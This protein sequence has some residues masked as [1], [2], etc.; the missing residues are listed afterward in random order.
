MIFGSVPTDLRFGSC[1][2]FSFTGSMTPRF[3][4]VRVC[5]FVSVR[6]HTVIIHFFIFITFITSNKSNQPICP[7]SSVFFWCLG[8]I[9]WTNLGS[10]TVFPGVNGDADNLCVNGYTQAPV[11]VF[12]PRMPTSKNQQVSKRRAYAMP[13]T[14][15]CKTHAINLSNISCSSLLSRLHDQ[16]QNVA[17]LH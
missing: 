3:V 9:H 14:L 1:G 16:K 17:L 10:L 12:W 11:Q 5:R 2:S 8:P 6:G 13:L 15:Q 7:N 4:P